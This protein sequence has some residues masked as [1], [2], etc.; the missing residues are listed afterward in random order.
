LI[1][2]NRAF[3]DTIRPFSPGAA[4]LNFTLE[5]DRVRDAYGEQKSRRL[6]AIKDER[7]PDNVFRM[8]QN[9]KPGKQ[10]ADAVAR[11]M[12]AR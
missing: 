10:T 3:A 5:A 6:V 9:I 7:D 8:N 11:E 12:A 4:Y 2:A 1:S